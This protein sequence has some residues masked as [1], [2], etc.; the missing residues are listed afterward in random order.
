MCLL[1]ELS[2]EVLVVE[3]AHG[4]LSITLLNVAIDARHQQFRG[5]ERTDEALPSLSATLVTMLT[6]SMLFEAMI[7]LAIDCLL[8]LGVGTACGEG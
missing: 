3:L 6:T 2:V 7:C 8:G 4:A 1:V 5:C